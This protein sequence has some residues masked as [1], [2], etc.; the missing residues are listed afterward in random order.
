LG[1]G[2]VGYG[3]SNRLGPERFSAPSPFV[4][5]G[6]ETPAAKKGVRAGG[7][8]DLKG[9]PGRSSAGRPISPGPHQPTTL[10]HP[11]PTRAHLEV[12]RRRRRRS[13]LAHAH[14]LQLH[15]RHRGVGR[16]A[17]CRCGFGLRTHISPLPPPYRHQLA[18]RLGVGWM[19]V[20]NRQA[21]SP[22]PGGGGLESWFACGMEH[23]CPAGGGR[24]KVMESPPTTQNTR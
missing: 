15:R 20:E 6:G 2:D 10:V 1:L 4:R 13:L 16:G 17:G 11:T 22:P 12:Q 19:L 24:R 3:P 9:G 18:S 7:L 23:R 8:W 14:G 21:P 5:R